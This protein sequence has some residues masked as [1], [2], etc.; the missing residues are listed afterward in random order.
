MAEVMEFEQEVGELE[1]VTAEIQ[2]QEQQQAA[3]EPEVDPDIPEKYRGKTVKD[4]VKMHQDTERSLSRQGQEL[5][6]IR[7]LADELIKS[8]L[9]PKKEPEQPKEVDYFENPDEAVSRRISNH[10]DVRAAKEYAEAAQKELAKQK[11]HQMHPDMDQIVSD[12][13]F[14][15]WVGASP[16]RKNLLVQADQGYDLAA[17]HELISTFKEIKSAKMAQQQRQ[18]SEVEKTSRNQAL[19]AAAVDTGGSGET[20]R[21]VYRRADLIKLKM[22]DPTRYDAM[23]D[24]ILAAYAEGRVR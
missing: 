9:Q 5:G 12:P 7:R 2:E 1:T 14:A 15:Q 4:I 21:K 10:P 8:Q 19:Q 17:A 18:V 22:T 23:N 11:I 16:V 6:E 24:E 13:E 3:P 20:T